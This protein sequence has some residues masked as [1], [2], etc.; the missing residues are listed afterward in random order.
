MNTGVMA[1]GETTNLTVEVENKRKSNRIDMK[2]KK[3]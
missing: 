1:P 2:K 3:V